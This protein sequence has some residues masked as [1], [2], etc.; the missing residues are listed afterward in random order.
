V[1]W[2]RRS[3]ATGNYEIRLQRVRNDAP[4]RIV[5]LFPPDAS[6]GCELT[7]PAA[8]IR[9]EHVA[10][11]G[12]EDAVVTEKCR[13]PNPRRCITVRIQAVYGTPR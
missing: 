13:R 7:Y 1:R 10:M 8:E 11:R 6:T 2:T 4:A 5:E 9:A 3:E 12:R